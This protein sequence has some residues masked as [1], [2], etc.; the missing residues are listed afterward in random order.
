MNTPALPNLRA[1]QD[2]I[3]ASAP[4]DVSELLT[5][6]IQSIVDCCETFPNADM[7]LAEQVGASV[8][9]AAQRGRW[10]DAAMSGM[11]GYETIHA[12]VMRGR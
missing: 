12:G 11:S 3:R 7:A 4:Q 10:M 5:D 9:Y 6:C 2:T 1:A 8:L